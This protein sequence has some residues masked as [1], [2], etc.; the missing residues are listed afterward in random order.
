VTLEQTTLQFVPILTLALVVA[1]WIY[2]LQ[3]KFK[4]AV[5]KNQIPDSGDTPED[6]DDK[7]TE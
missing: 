6:L 4:G 7:K 3:G 1:G 5:G 2:V